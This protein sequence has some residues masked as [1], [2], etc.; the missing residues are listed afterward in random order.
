L[1]RP[2]GKDLPIAYASRTL[3]KVEINYITTEKEV[4]SIVWRI[5]VY[6]PYLFGQKFN[7]ITNHRALVWLLNL[8]DPGSRLTL[9]CLILE[10]YKYTIYYK[11]GFSNTNADTLSR[12][13]KVT[14][15]LSKFSETSDPSKYLDIA[16]TAK[17]SNLPVSSEHSDTTKL[18]EFPNSSEPLNLNLTES[19]LLYKD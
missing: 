4:S 7:I 18:M 13:H 2:V 16:E 6:K 19:L 14:T 3:N 15:R 9:W 12:I 11:P 17:T 8:K 1:Q 5:K 10:E